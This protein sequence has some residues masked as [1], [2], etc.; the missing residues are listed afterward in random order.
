MVAKNF[1][2]KIKEG[3]ISG[4]NLTYQKIELK[5]DIGALENLIATSIT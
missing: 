5:N 4:F 1:D 2:K 3:K